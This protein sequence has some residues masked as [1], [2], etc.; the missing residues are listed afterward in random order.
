MA[1]CNICKK[2]L[3]YKSS[4][5]N[6]KRHLQNRHPTVSIPP[7]PSSKVNQRPPPS[8]ATSLRE[9]DHDQDEEETEVICGSE[10]QN[11]DQGQPIPGPSSGESTAVAFAGTKKR[12]QEMISAFI[13]KKLSGAAKKK[14]DAALL[15]LFIADLQPFSVVE[16]I[17]FR[18]FVR[19][20]NSAYELPNRKTISNSLIPALYEE[21]KNRVLESM[22]DIL[23]ISLTTDCWTSI[24]NESFMAVTAHFID[25]KFEMKSILLEC[26][27]LHGGHTSSNLSSVLDRIVKY[28]GLEKKLVA[29]VSDNAAN[30]KHA[31]STDLGWKHFGCFAHTL[32]LVVHNALEIVAGTL[33]KVK[34][35]V[36]HFRKSTNSNSLL[37]TTQRQ[38]GINS[39]KKLVQSVTTRWNS[40][41]YMVERFVELEEV[42]KATI[43]RCRLSGALPQIDTDEW[44][45]LKEMCKILHPFED[46]TK[47]VSGEKYASASLVIVLTNG[48]VNV[49]SILATEELKATSLR[50]VTA[51][52]TGLQTRLVNVEYSNTLAVC[53][54]LD[55]R[56]KTFCFQNNDAVDKV[57]KS[58]T[59]CLTQIINKTVNQS[60]SRSRSTQAT[61]ADDNRAQTVSLTVEPE[62]E[63]R[64]SAWDSLQQNLA[65]HQPRFSASARAIMEFQRYLEDE[66]LDQQQNPLEWWKMNEHNYPYL[67]QVVRRM[68]C[69]L[70][71]SVPCERLFSKAG[72]ILE[73]RR[74]RLSAKKLEY[75]LFL[76]TNRHILECND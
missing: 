16:D 7:G 43:P 66:V 55:P 35:I 18:K 41:F 72:R 37:F 63:K 71:T 52:K 27:I 53:T 11:Q 23:K 14:I 29:A 40:T 57:K 44:T 48:L 1:E 8:T 67:S 34:G 3:C 32:N 62:K 6:L 25:K 5:T 45:I 69:V 47:S 15:D 33:E 42:L 2:H 73:E 19:A 20:L 10:N 13:P 61:Q 46:A 9:G 68:C 28:W 54:L 39:P 51:L 76:N 38:F 21:C 59:E 22:K 49:C 75:L 30:I 65:Q 26:A 60:R 17:G 12:K 58:V 31:I 24:N 70:A 74:T 4:I 50:L 36:A 56:F 64:L